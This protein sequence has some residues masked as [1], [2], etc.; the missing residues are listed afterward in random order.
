M[1]MDRK[2]KLDEDLTTLQAGDIARFRDRQARELSRSTANLGNAVKFWSLLQRATLSKVG[3]TASVVTLLP[4][5]RHLVG[6]SLRARER[7]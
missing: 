5:N 6:R 7:F 4:P 3:R 2:P 1:G